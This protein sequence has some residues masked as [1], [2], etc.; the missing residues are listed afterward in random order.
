[1]ILIN[2]ADAQNFI[3]GFRGQ[4]DLFDKQAFEELAKIKKLEPIIFGAY[5]V[6]RAF[7]FINSRNDKYELYGYSLGAWSVKQVLS[8][9]HRNKKRM[10]THITTVGAHHTL[11]VDF[12]DYNVGFS[13]YFDNGGKKNKSPGT[14]I[15]IPHHRIMQHVTDMYKLR[16]TKGKIY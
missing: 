10:P 5:E 11:K 2:P 9:Q 8:L 14:Y 3:V 1:M 7:K 15:D 16:Y 6:D 4:Q 12:T 13:N